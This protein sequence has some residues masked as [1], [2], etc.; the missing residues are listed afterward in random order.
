MSN[1]NVLNEGKTHRQH[2]T[3][4]RQKQSLCI[5][6]TVIREKKKLEYAVTTGRI[7]R[8]RDRGRQ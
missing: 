5:V 6:Y 8:K 7:C 3:N 4:I 2:I 1:L